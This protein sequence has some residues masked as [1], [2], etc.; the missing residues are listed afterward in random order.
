MPEVATALLVDGWDSPALRRAAGADGDDPE[1]QRDGFRRAL[2]E[3]DQLPLTPEEA[4]ARL[5]SFWAKR[6]LDHEV[7]RSKALRRSGLFTVTNGVSFDDESFWGYGTLDPG[8]YAA[9]GD[10]RASHT[11]TGREMARNP[12]RLTAGEF[13]IRLKG[14]SRSMPTGRSHRTR[15]EPLRAAST[16]GRAGRRTSV[17]AG[18]LLSAPLGEKRKPTAPFSEHVWDGRAVD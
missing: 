16:R 2:E 11:R 10:L 9:P 14:A 1:Q 8:E 13:R 17:I 18:L 6:I 3:L 7:P 12:R 15:S 5:T 4:A